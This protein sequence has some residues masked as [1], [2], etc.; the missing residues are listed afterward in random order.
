[1]WCIAHSL[2]TRA[3]GSNDIPTNTFNLEDDNKGGLSTS[4][5]V[6]ILLG[7]LVAVYALVNIGIWLYKS[8]KRGFFH[9]V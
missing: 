8:Y 4:E 9:F 7:S 6:G 3:P 2:G 1:M 5:F